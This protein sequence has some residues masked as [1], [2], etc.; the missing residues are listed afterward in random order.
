MLRTGRNRPLKEVVPAINT[1]NVYRRAGCL[2]NRCQA[3]GSAV[4][5]TLA[6][7]NFVSGATLYIANPGVAISNVTVASATQI[8]AT[9][10]IPPD[11]GTGAFG[12]EV[13]QN[14]CLRSLFSQSLA[15]RVASFL[16][17]SDQ[18]LATELNQ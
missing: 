8:S 7:T 18:P 14:T 10:A 11:A 5:V 3:L 12:M 9:F 6:G 15:R 1:P 16:I 2:Y 13:A 17:E 4:I